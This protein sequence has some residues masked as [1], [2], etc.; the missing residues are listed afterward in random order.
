MIFCV[1]LVGMLVF[2]FVGYIN[3]NLGQMVA[4]INYNG[5]FCGYG[6][7]EGFGYLYIYDLTAA[8][9]DTDAFWNYGIC[10]E[11]CPSEG[12]TINCPSATQTDLDIDCGNDV[13]DRYDTKNSLSYCVP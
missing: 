4:P 8:T 6:S 1:F 13:T 12:D 2:S 3:G 11:N 10:V 7:Q 9:A 5:D